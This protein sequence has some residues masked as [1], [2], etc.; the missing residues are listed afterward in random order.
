[1]DIVL[2]N[3]GLELFTDLCLADFLLS[4][5]YADKVVLHGK[6][7][8]WF[9]SDTTSIDL[10]WM[11]KQLSDRENEKSLRKIG[12]RWTSL[13]SNKGVEYKAHAFWT[14]WFPYDEMLI[15]AR[16][17]YSELSTS[18]LVIFKGDLNYRWCKVL[19]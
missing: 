19:H 6:A 18:S 16:D 5:Q 7:F 17:L 2:D 1:M 3:A 15:K 10:H 9:V 11:L 8:P 14:H 13:L 12:Q 4:K